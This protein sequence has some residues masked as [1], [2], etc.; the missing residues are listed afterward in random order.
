MKEFCIGMGVVCRK[1]KMV[2]ERFLGVFGVLVLI[3]VAMVVL[4]S[5]HE[6][7]VMISQQQQESSSSSSSS[8]L[9]TTDAYEKIESYGFPQGILPH[10]IKS[11]ILEPSGRFTLYLEGECKVLIQSKYPLEYDK[12]ITG[13]L[14]YGQLQQLQ[15]IRV[16]AF[17]VWWSIT[18][19]S[20]SSDH[21]LLFSFGILSA[22]FPL[23]N[24]DDPPICERKLSEGGGGGDLPAWSF[25]FNQGFSS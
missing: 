22:K 18:T 11:Y 23:D 21:D 13:F 2:R 19:I 3:C 7:V 15:G 25:F 6:E 4:V 5:A 20:R 12:T 1:L 14:S 8:A 9:T 24:F 10:T 16:K 17:Y